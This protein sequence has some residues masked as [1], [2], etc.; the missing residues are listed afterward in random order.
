MSVIGI[1]YDNVL[2]I[3]FSSENGTSIWT[4]EIALVS[5]RS[6]PV[7]YEELAIQHVDSTPI[8]DS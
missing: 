4:F 8:I 5:R 1:L 6:A 7:R 2:A 3:V